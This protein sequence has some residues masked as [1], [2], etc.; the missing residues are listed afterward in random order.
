MSFEIT[1]WLIM[2]AVFGVFLCF[3]KLEQWGMEQRIKEAE[4]KGYEVV[5]M[6]VRS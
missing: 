6:E 2:V 1:I 5:I 3:D 4:E